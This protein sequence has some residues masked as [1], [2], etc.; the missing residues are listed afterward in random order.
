MAD[1]MTKTFLR[2]LRIILIMAAVCHQMA[3]VWTFAGR[4]ADLNGEDSW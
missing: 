2:I 4:S 1:G 3:C